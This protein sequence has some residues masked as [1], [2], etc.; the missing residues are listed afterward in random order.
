MFADVRM[1]ERLYESQAYG[2]ITPERLREGLNW[3]ILHKDY[4]DSL[5]LGALDELRR[6]YK[7]VFANEVFV[8][9]T[10]KVL[11]GVE[12]GF[13]PVHEQA[14]WIKMETRKSGAIDQNPA[15]RKEALAGNRF[16]LSFRK[17]FLSL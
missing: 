8:V 12:P 4:A 11:P 10:N 7:V 14:L 17:F 15:R 13:D 9:F 6:S 3:V 1:L 2:E 16:W 5:E